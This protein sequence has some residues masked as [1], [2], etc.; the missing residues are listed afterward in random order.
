MWGVPCELPESLVSQERIAED[1]RFLE[2]L[3]QHFST[4][5]EKLSGDVR[6]PFTRKSRRI[7]GLAGQIVPHFYRARGFATKNVP[8]DFE[9]YSHM[10]AAR[11][12]WKNVKR[13]I[14]SER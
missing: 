5:R 13:V 8:R 6:S 9:Y 1:I 14:E 11:R 2:K 7:K 4:L 3:D 12:L 10:Q